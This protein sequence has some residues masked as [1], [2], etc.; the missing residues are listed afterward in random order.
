MIRKTA[1]ALASQ[2]KSKSLVSLG[3]SQGENLKYILTKSIHE[4]EMSDKSL[5]TEILSPGST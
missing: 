1:A 3:N 4:E 5:F 2:F